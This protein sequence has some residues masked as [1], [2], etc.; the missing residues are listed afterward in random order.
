MSSFSFF[1][2]LNSSKSKKSSEESTKSLN[3]S[4]DSS[5]TSLLKD[6]TGSRVSLSML[7]KL[8]FWK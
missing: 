1:S 6:L 3:R 5:F 2:L 4:I 8:S 7:N